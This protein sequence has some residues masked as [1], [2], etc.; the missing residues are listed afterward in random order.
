[1]E[2]KQGSVEGA[3]PAL[4]PVAPH[5]IATQNPQ[6]LGATPCQITGWTAFMRISLW[7]I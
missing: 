5:L 1:M 2:E 4:P 3:H 7:R 6:W